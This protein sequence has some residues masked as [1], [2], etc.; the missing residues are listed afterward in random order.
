MRILGRA[1]LAAVFLAGLAVV[2]FRIADMATTAQL[3]RSVQ[4]VNAAGKSDRGP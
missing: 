2:G 3:D 4:T 1:T